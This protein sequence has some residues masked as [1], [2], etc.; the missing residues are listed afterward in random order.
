MGSGSTPALRAF[1][2]C[3][4]GC[5]R[6]HRSRRAAMTYEELITFTG[7]QPLWTVSRL[8][9]ALDVSTDFIY[10][11][12]QRDEIPH[13]RL[14]TNIRFHYKDILVWVAK[15]RVVPRR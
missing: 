4:L 5:R 10:Q 13:I 6:D 15:N 7:P 2:P 12:V 3:E 8:A 9:E 14:G 11:A 1:G